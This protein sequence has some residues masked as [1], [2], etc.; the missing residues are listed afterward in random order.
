MESQSMCV[1]AL[2][3]LA[4]LAVALCVFASLPA[5]ADGQ[6]SSTTFINNS[7]QGKYAYV[8]NTGDVASLGP[9]KFDGNGKLRL[10]IVTNV[11][12]VTPAPGCSRVI[13]RFDVSGI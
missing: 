5:M 3:M 8:N 6:E 9:I 13:G 12:C 4:H 1:M 11:P 2:R 10:Q 7:L